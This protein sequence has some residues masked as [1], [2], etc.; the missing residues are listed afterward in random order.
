VKQP[1]PHVEP[2]TLRDPY[3]RDILKS[4]TTHLHKTIR[5]IR[6]EVVNHERIIPLNIQFLLNTLQKVECRRFTIVHCLEIG[7]QPIIPDEFDRPSSIEQDT[8]TRS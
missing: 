7:I 3:A 2:S 5:I 1:T 4:V 6:V 8:K